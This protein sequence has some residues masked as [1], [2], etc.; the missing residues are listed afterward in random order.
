MKEVDVAKPVV[1]YFKEMGY[2]VYQEVTVNNIGIADIVATKG[3]MVCVVEV[4]KSMSLQL[5]AQ[6]NSWVG[7]THCV[8]IATPCLYRPS[9]QHRFINGLM[10]SYGIGY[11][12]VSTSSRQP[13]QIKLRPRYM[14]KAY[15]NLIK[16]SL[17]EAQKDFS[18]AGNADGKRW[19]PF[20]ETLRKLTQ[21]VAD[22]PGITMKEAINKLS[23][24][25]SSDA[26]AK[27]AIATLIHRGEIKGLE[28]IK[29]DN[30]NRLFIQRKTEAHHAL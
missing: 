21:I 16:S 24:H 8:Y 17:F 26:S 30:M 27:N 9:K 25:Y 20:Q 14:R 11:L 22:S 6:A 5:L 13:L 23:H 4:K 3:K 19:T 1:A 10:H 2:D 29:E 12:E 18:E 28:L 7:Y 15:V